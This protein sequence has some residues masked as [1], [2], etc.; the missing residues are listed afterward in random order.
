ML[1]TDVT[2]V[3][4]MRLFALSLHAHLRLASFHGKLRSFSSPTC[5]RRNTRFQNILLQ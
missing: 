5:K 1:E 4:E 2:L 3:D